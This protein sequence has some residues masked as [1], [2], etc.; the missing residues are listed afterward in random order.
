MTKTCRNCPTAIEKGSYCKPCDA[1]RSR[2]NYEKNREKRIETMRAWR[3]ANP[4]KAYQATKN[5][6]VNNPDKVRV[7]DSNKRVRREF[8]IADQVLPPDTLEILKEKF[9]ETCLSPGC[10]RVDVTMD[11]VVPLVLGGRH[12]IDNLQL[13]CISHNSSKGGRN[14]NDYRNLGS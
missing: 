3:A 4:D 10:D 9:G 8:L 6:K 14:S 11:H 5:W 1:E 2:I 7:H 13:L 12:H